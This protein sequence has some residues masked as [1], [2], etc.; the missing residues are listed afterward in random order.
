MASLTRF[1][2]DTRPLALPAYRRLWTASVVVAVGGQLT[3]IA[4]PKQLFDLT[5]SSAW[6]GLAGLV[7]FL[8][9]AV[10]AL[11]GGGLADVA[12]RR[13][14]L[15][16]TNVG[17][18]TTL[19]LFGLQA[20]LHLGSVPLLMVLVAVQMSFVGANLS[21][22]GAAIPRVVPAELVPAASGL[23]SLVRQVGSIVGPLLAGVLIPVI[24]LPVLY[25]LDAVALSAVLWAVH[26][27]PAMPPG[28]QAPRRTDLRHLAD[29]FRYLAR[30]R[31]LVAVLAADL[32]A[33]VFG[34]PYALFPELARRTFGD[35]A[36]GGLALGL[37]YA[38]YPAG[39][40]AMGLVSGTVTRSRRHG[41]LVTVA[42]TAWGATLVGLGLSRA[43]WLGLAFLVIGGAVNFV[44]S[45][46]RNAITQTCATD[47]MRGRTQGAFT[48]I[49]MGGPAL[50]NVAHGAA[51]AAFGPA[52]AIAGGGVL[53]VLGMWT[54]VSL[55]PDFWRYRAPAATPA[56]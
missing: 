34:M 25:L 1:A 49:T 21:A 3:L 47:E 18:A 32:V 43:L 15:L 46:F 52:W 11:W 24:G 51:G 4:V 40:L 29:G 53:V 16:V 12:D 26:R 39:V 23:G 7:S 50:A 10:S 8:A 9:L 45:T 22:M 19:G 35:P 20:V 28:A 33:M 14:M 5:G 13:R 54:V 17:L 2:V 36:E 55:A 44:L 30:G 31:V 38:A 6:V 42:V 56:G 37:L 27:L 48:V 41:M